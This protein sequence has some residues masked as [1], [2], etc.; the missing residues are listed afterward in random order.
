[1]LRRRY[2]ILVRTF[3]NDGRAVPDEAFNEIRGD[4]LAR[5][6]GLSW[7]PE[8][9]QEVWRDDA[10]TAEVS[11]IRVVIDVEDSA[12]NRQFFVDW[13]PTLLRRFG[14]VEINSLSA[15]HVL[16]QRLTAAIRRILSGRNWPD[17]RLAQKLGT[18]PPEMSRILGNTTGLTLERL[19]SIADALEVPVLLLF[20]L[21]QPRG[22]EWN[23]FPRRSEDQEIRKLARKAETC[24]E[25]LIDVLDDLIKRNLKVI[26]TSSATGPI[27]PGGSKSHGRA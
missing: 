22:Q 24:H 2:E 25:W 27:A 3:F 19:V 5:F 4:L 26:K 15:R 9:G 18:S 14:E 1:M 13:K 21:A 20:A 16:E 7:V 8:P 6:R 17:G 10:T 11:G 23:W 12:E